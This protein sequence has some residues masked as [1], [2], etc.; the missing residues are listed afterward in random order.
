ME[1]LGMW[2]VHMN[3]VFALVCR[4]GEEWE[5][6][7]SV[8]CNNQHLS[9]CTSPSPTSPR[10]A[11][12][13]SAKGAAA[14][15]KL[16]HNV[17]PGRNTASS[18]KSSESDRASARLS[19]TPA[20]SNIGQSLSGRSLRL[21]RLQVEDTA[22][23]PD[24]QTESGNKK[25]VLQES[26]G[27]AKGGKIAQSKNTASITK[28]CKT[29]V[30]N[31]KDSPGSRN[32]KPTQ[33]TGTK[34]DM[35]QT[36]HSSSPAT[37]SSRSSGVGKK[38]I[39]SDDTN[40]S[41]IAG[42][43]IK[44][45]APGD[46]QQIVISPAVTTRSRRGKRS[47]PSEELT[48]KLHVKDPQNK[49]DIS[50]SS[51]T[52]AVSE[53]AGPTKMTPGETRKVSTKR[54]SSVDKKESSVSK[55]VVVQALS[56]NSIPGRTRRSAAK[57]SGLAKQ[58]LQ[59]GSIVSV[60]SKTATKEMDENLKQATKRDLEQPETSSVAKR[61]R[62]NEQRETIAPDVNKSS[63]L[64]SKESVRAGK[65]RAEQTLQGQK[66]AETKS[67]KQSEPAHKKEKLSENDI[68]DASTDKERKNKS[69]ADCDIKQED[70]CDVISDNSHHADECQVSKVQTVTSRKAAKNNT[71][72]PEVTLAVRLL[73]VEHVLDQMAQEIGST[74]AESKVEDKSELHSSD[75]EVLKIKDEPLSFEERVPE[76][77]SQAPDRI[78][79]ATNS[80]ESVK[81]NAS[82][83]V[84]S[85]SKETK[86]EFGNKEVDG[87]IE[88]NKIDVSG[89]NKGIDKLPQDTNIAN[90]EDDKISHNADIKRKGTIREMDFSLQTVN[91][92]SKETIPEIDSASQNVNVE[93]K[94]IPTEMDNTSQNACVANKETVKKM[95]I[96][97]QTVSV[98]N[99]ETITEMDDASQNVSVENKETIKEVDNTLHN[100]SVDNKEINKT[101]QI[102]NVVNKEENT[103]FQDLS[104]RNM[105]IN[106]QLPDADK[107][108]DDIES[109]V[110]KSDLHSDDVGVEWQEV[111]YVSQEKDEGNKCEHSKTNKPVNT[112]E[113]DHDELKKVE[114][115]IETNFESEKAESSAS[116]LPSEPIDDG[117]G[118]CD[119]LQ[120]DKIERVEIKQEIL[121]LFEDAECD[122]AVP[123]E[124]IDIKLEDEI[125]GFEVVAEWSSLPRKPVSR[126]DMVEDSAAALEPI[127]SSKPGDHSELLMPQIT[128]NSML[129]GS[130][131]QG[132]VISSSCSKP[133]AA[134]DK[135]SSVPQVSEAAR[136]NEINDSA[137]L[138]SCPEATESSL[139]QIEQSKTPCSHS[140]LQSEQDSTQEA[141]GASSN[142][143][144]TSSTTDTEIK[145]KKANFAEQIHSERDK[146]SLEPS[147][148]FASTLE[149]SEADDVVI[150]GVEPA[151]HTPKAVTVPPPVAKLL[152]KVCSPKMFGEIIN[153]KKIS[154]VPKSERVKE[155]GQPKPG[156]LKYSVCVDN[157]VQKE[158]C[159]PEDT[160][161]IAHSIGKDNKMNILDPALAAQLPG[162]IFAPKSQAEHAQIK[163]HLSSGKTA[164]INLKKH[165]EVSAEKT[166]F[167]G[168]DEPVTLPLRFHVKDKNLGNAESNANVTDGGPPFL[169][170]TTESIRGLSEELMTQVSVTVHSLPRKRKE[171]TV[172]GLLVYPKKLKRMGQANG[173]SLLGMSALSASL[174]DCQ[175][176]KGKLGGKANEQNSNFIG[177]KTT[178]DTTV[179]DDPIPE[180]TPG[181]IVPRPYGRLTTAGKHFFD[182][183]EENC[184]LSP[185]SKAFAETLVKQRDFL[186]DPRHCEALEKIG[187]VPI[188]L[189]TVELLNSD[190][191]SQAGTFYSSAPTTSKQTLESEEIERPNRSCPLLA[192]IPKFVKGKSQ[193]TLLPNLDDLDDLMEVQKPVE[194]RNILSSKSQVVTL[195]SPVSTSI[196]KPIIVTSAG[197]SAPIIST[198]PYSARSASTKHI[199]NAT[200]SVSITL[201]TSDA[202]SQQSKTTRQPKMVSLLPTSGI[203]N[204]SGSS[205][206]IPSSQSPGIEEASESS[207]KLQKGHPETS[208]LAKALTEPQNEQEDSA[209][210]S[211]TLVIDGNSQTNVS[212]DSSKQLHEVPATVATKNGTRIVNGELIL[213]Q[214][215]TYS[216]DDMEEDFY[217]NTDG[218]IIPKKSRECPCP[219]CDGTGHITGQY[220]HHRSLSGCPRRNTLSPDVFE[221]LMKKTDSGAKCPTVG[222]NG[223]GH[224][225]NN[226]STHRSVSG[227]P[228]AAMN[229]LMSIK[230][231]KQNMH[232]VVLPKSDDPTKAMIATCSEKEL[233][234]LAAKEITPAGTDRVL[235]PMILTK[236]LEP[237]DSKLAPQVTPRGNLAKE[238][239]KYSRPELGQQSSSSDT[240][241]QAGGNEDRTNSSDEVPKS[242]AGP[243]VEPTA[244]V[245]EAVRNAPE[246]PNILSRR[247]HVRHKP[248]MLSRSRPGGSTGNR[249]LDAA[250]AAAA[251]ARSSSPSS[252][253]S[254]SS[255]SLLSSSPASALLVEQLSA[256]SNLSQKFPRS[257]ED[258]SEVDEDEAEE[259]KP[260]SVCSASPV[261]SRS[262]S[263]SSLLLMK[264]SDG[265]SSPQPFLE[266]LTPRSGS[267]RPKSEATCPTPGCDGSGHVTGNY[268]SHRSLSGC[269]LAD[270]ATVQANQ[271]EQK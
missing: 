43:V 15:I 128:G 142:P 51:Q 130:T 66:E 250:A 253:S 13:I 171:R 12:D 173:L 61:K 9:S 157:E 79:N 73:K 268:T 77:W 59:S 197:F 27:S 170:T 243:H 137:V 52:K 91:V 115:K 116:V 218:V 258:N 186:E 208:L 99:K 228:L 33:D 102:T 265:A 72:D 40:S 251:S 5:N 71:Y 211:G 216:P 105:D 63:K 261:S 238:L 39:D 163:L 84:H 230:E 19:K 95:D 165:Y 227:C 36:I 100:V 237:R 183:I 148:A 177:S 26:P 241:L 17:S 169:R 121:E 49:T 125:E 22:K 110:F 117:L 172:P 42:T 74:S 62:L 194:S 16:Q 80:K 136:V 188:T 123:V 7:T 231:S 271:V 132:S 167:K 154:F 78:L 111:G 263:P 257:N 28:S 178:K 113:I 200:P 129:E 140:S 135:G 88:S 41:K 164:L 168:S 158:V 236:Q 3:T 64:S 229:K 151:S 120:Y 210:S 254:S 189:D 11:R 144:N 204:V 85:E 213:P 112:G 190:T 44:E 119:T 180:E 176:L 18:K 86:E 83:T 184:P 127:A 94:E 235:R 68:N 31:T 141:E 38:D 1:C 252:V 53:S 259:P 223:R 87:S 217:P 81:E 245:K 76:D 48:S 220:T 192:E 219:G 56:E 221:A 201:A 187:L 69:H 133:G 50:G 97:L 152:Q 215:R 267:S 103:K 101:S 224:I 202:V 34:L 54:D 214:L 55:E 270:R 60:E 146:S 124:D 82:E 46:L 104:E 92:E 191:K 185:G 145:E 156:H 193:M 10:E 20:T 209:V 205:Q 138:K 89:E 160:V 162:N 182:E 206:T 260:H 24:T 166:P 58:D 244:A 264:T 75:P 234:R 247:P 242:G 6:Q 269:P 108:T 35:K 153:S 23:T 199:T 98:E 222:C 155:R 195:Q 93:N 248:S 203:V 225:N 107:E 175:S 32:R 240:T 262:P 109:I 147:N 131:D 255:S 266:L 8:T 246:R 122:E 57:E 21:S 256:S 134:E 159:I 249:I 150:T 233:I 90:K 179:D 47:E 37:R 67:R 126:E 2:H 25:S 161:Q 207:Q 143:P 114:I 14:E 239:E 96:I 106:K 30:Q 181:L 232:V 226:R 4:G 174:A 65:R 29:L 70:S 212:V 45:P 149:I 196:P 139:V 118:N 198:L